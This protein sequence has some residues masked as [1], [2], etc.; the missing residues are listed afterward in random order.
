LIEK[1][2]GSKSKCFLNRMIFKANPE[3]REKE[4][5]GK[6]EAV[7]GKRRGIGGVTKN[8]RLVERSWGNRAPYKK[9][10]GPAGAFSS[11]ASL[12]GVENK[13]QEG[14]SRGGHAD[15]RRGEGIHP[16]NNFQGRLKNS[17][18]HGRGG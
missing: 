7:G 5:H 10:L 17:R 12:V 8:P 1:K 4:Q 18:K 15:E 3:K 2:D 9:L 6:T 16:V 11:L 13:S 14:K